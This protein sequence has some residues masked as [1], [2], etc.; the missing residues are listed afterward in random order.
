VFEAGIPNGFGGCSY[1]GRHFMGGH[2]LIERFYEYV[3]VSI[4][5]VLYCTVRYGMYVEVMNELIKIIV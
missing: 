4:G 2:G 3:L 5:T 1:S